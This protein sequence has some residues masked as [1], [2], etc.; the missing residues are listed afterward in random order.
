MMLIWMTHSKDLK[1]EILSINTVHSTKTE[2]AFQNAKHFAD[3]TL[4]LAKL[5]YYIII[6][7]VGFPP[8]LSLFK[9]AQLQFAT[10]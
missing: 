9:Y 1:F 2:A 3:G 7:I 4:Y 5:S 10:H 8:V 6:S